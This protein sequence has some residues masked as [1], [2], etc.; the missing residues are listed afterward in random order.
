MPS[1]QERWA[2]SVMERCARAAS[3][4]AMAAS[5][6]E[7]PNKQQSQ[8][9]RVLVT[10]A[11][12]LLGRQVMEAL[13]RENWEVRG[14]CHSSAEQYP[15]LISCDLTKEGEAARQVEEFQPYAVLHL[16]AEWRPDVLRRSPA[17]TRRLNVDATGAIAAACQRCG[18]WLIHLSADSVFD[19]RA[20]PYSVDAVANPLSEYGWHKLHG[21][22]L[23]LVACPRAAVLRVALL[24]GPCS[25]PSD[26]AVTSL[27]TDLVHGVRE[28]DAWQQCYPTS[29]A[30]VAGV[31]V[32][33]LRLHKFG[34][35]ER[36]RGIFHWQGQEQFTW[37]EMMLLVAEI[38][39][40][41]ASDIIAVHAPPAAPLPRDCRLDC[42]RLESVLGSDITDGLRTSF[43]DGLRLCLAPFVVKTGGVA[44]LSGVGAQAAPVADTLQLSSP[45]LEPPTISEVSHHGG[46]AASQAAAAAQ[47]AAEDA[48]RNAN[49]MRRLLGGTS[50]N[51]ISAREV[52]AESAVE[53]AASRTTAEVTASASEQASASVGSWSA[54]QPAL[55]QSSCGSSRARSGALPGE[56]PEAALSAGLQQTSQVAETV[57]D[58][59]S[60]FRDELK[61]RGAALQEL[62]WQELERT[63]NRLKEAGLSEGRRGA[64]CNGGGLARERTSSALERSS[65]A[66][67]GG[68]LSRF[69]NA[70][71]SSGEA[72][73]TAAWLLP[74]RRLLKVDG[75]A[76]S[77]RSSAAKA[78]ESRGAESRSGAAR[79]GSGSAAPSSARRRGR[80]G[81]RQ[82][83]AAGGGALGSGGSSP[84]GG[85]SRFRPWSQ[86]GEERWA[87]AN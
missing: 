73:S 21:E 42:S 72:A 11:S 29:S 62:F 78:E 20:A 84:T 55:Q 46:L 81:T 14:L 54:H 64:L 66:A 5:R 1:A 51:S 43:R 19:G 76:L 23:T 75:C 70:P 57:L 31:L 48:I 69:S 10:G 80:S 74:R 40:L 52:R 4:T 77:E 50:T 37:H 27:H 41:D 85:G 60:E 28:V 83:G 79:D 2:A 33:M 12:G 44:E 45:P 9:H 26:S 35:G 82:S 67:Q 65:S 30:D 25:Q 22:Q 63:R 13:K 56:D 34:E 24:Y 47:A 71:A 16:A 53:A 17:R 15:H 18:A 8:K 36:L 32:A 61:K 59:E 7:K 68:G 39:G 3:S 58:P 6:S 87:S 86:S 49:A 38:S